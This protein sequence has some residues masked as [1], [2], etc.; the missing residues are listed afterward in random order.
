MCIELTKIN[1]FTISVGSQCFSVSF[2]LVGSWISRRTWINL[3]SL[4]YVLAATEYVFDSEISYHD[5]SSYISLWKFNAIENCRK[6]QKCTIKSNLMN[7]VTRNNQSDA[8]SVDNKYIASSI[9]YH[10]IFINF[11]RKKCVHSKGATVCIQFSSLKRNC[12][13]GKYVLI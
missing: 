10:A 4:L 9:E 11:C 12:L 6:A 13:R 2:L 7:G 5:W 3:C 1:I 8:Q